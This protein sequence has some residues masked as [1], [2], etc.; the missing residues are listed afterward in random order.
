V[1]LTGVAY[2]DRYVIV[3]AR[4]LRSGPE[5]TAH[6]RVI[7]QARSWLVNTGRPAESTVILRLPARVVWF[8]RYSLMMQLGFSGF[9]CFSGV[10]AG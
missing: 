9:S 1:L 10:M 5:L 7:A 4:A 2:R 3:G 6:P 8:R